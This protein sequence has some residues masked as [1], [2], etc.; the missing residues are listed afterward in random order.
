MKVLIWATMNH[1]DDA[2]IR[3]A[4][5]ANGIVAVVEKVKADEV[6]PGTDGE[7]YRLDVEVLADNEDDAVV[8]VRKRLLEIFAPHCQ[9]HSAV[10]YGESPLIPSD[11]TS[12][13]TDVEVDSEIT[14]NP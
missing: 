13:R 1:R 12:D 3:A 14:D 10:V 5:E 11:Q 4:L 7:I 9:I 6:I 8:A 2:T